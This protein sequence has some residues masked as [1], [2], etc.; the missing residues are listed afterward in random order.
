M[1]SAK[2]AKILTLF[3]NLDKN[4]ELFGGVF[5]KDAILRSR[6]ITSK[7]GIDFG[8]IYFDG[9]V[10]NE[11]IN[12]SVIRP[13]I[14]LSEDFP[15][16]RASFISRRCLF[17]GDVKTSQKCE[18]VIRAV[19]YGDVAL[20]TE[21]CD[22]ALL[23]N[24]KGWRQ[25]GISEPENERILQGPRE[26]FD[27]AG[28]FNVALIRRKLLT[29][30]FSVEVMR[31]GERTDT[32]VFICYLDSLCDDKLL[33]ELRH[34][35]SKI[36]IDGVL[37][38]NYI[39]EHIRDF[40]GSLFK[41]SGTTERP[42]I[43]AANLLEGRVAL[44][45]DGTP[46]VLTV[47]YLFA[48]NFQSD[49]DYYTNYKMASVSRILRAVCFI[50]SIT[51][52]GLYLSVISFNAG[53]LPAKF[54]LFVS[55]SRAGVPFTPL[56]ECIVLLFA[57][58]ILKESGLRMPQSVG[59][60]LGIVGGLVVGQSAVEA[61]VVS[62][63]LLI[64]V[65]LAG[66]A[67]LTVPRLRTAVFFYRLLITLLATAFGIYGV[68]GGLLLM[69]CRITEIRSF[70]AEYTEALRDLS[71]ET[72]KDTAVRNSWTRMI[73]RPSIQNKNKKRQKL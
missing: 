40:K 24:A 25:R 39:N 73:R 72:L 15:D 16:D 18:D 38:T 9:M 30:D 66:I 31:I 33:R 46:V 22:K 2:D 3:K 49:E 7:S 71:P 4:M 37:D 54:A 59:H 35:L 61:R 50:I 29:P 69:L 53:L 8:I 26:G 60:A 64:A 1:Q 63:P 55:A 14:L 17:S 70:G 57:F 27:E 47:P 12:E 5:K 67:G 43:V 13:L 11:L 36:N 44:I 48:E 41:T 42:D 51:L 23:I 32:F 6:R 68:A 56:T 65:A 10:N 52:P 28:M 62:A 21:G 20:F 58:E 45:V 19:L 34:R